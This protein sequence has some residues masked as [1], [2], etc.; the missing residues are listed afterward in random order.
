MPERVSNIRMCVYESPMTIEPD[1]ITRLVR[2]CEPGLPVDPTDPRYVNCDDVRGDFLVQSI[3]RSLQRAD[4][5]HPDC[6][7]FAGHRG[8]GKSSE[9]LRLK[10]MLERPASGQSPFRVIY[11][12]VAT[13]LDLNDLD[14]PDLLVYAAA[15]IQRQLRKAA[16]PKFSG[17]SQ[18]LQR[19]WD[20]FKGFLG[21]SVQFSGADVEIPF[22]SLP[23][24]FKNQPSGRETLRAG[25]ERVSTSL[26]AAVNELLT[27]ANLSLQDA[28]EKGVALIID[29]LDKLVLRSLGNGQTTHDRLFLDRGE[30]LASLRAHTIYTVP[31]SMI[32]SPRCTQLEQAFGEF[33]RPVAMIRLRGD[34]RSE[35]T[36]DTL[37]MQKLW[38]IVK[39]RCAFA[40]VD[41]ND[42]FDSEETCNYLCRMTGGHPRH[43]MVFLQAAANE[44]DSLPITRRAAERVV[45]SYA[46]S[47]LREIPTDFWPRLRE[48]ATP[49]DDIPKDEAHQEMLFY[50]HV[51]EYM[52][53]RPWYEVNPVLRTLPIFD[54]A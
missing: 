12:D 1:P 37:G 27:Q 44:C 43:L 6:K 36:P 16:I 11:F 35:P 30:Q 53:C 26:L 22:A 49:R 51:L 9:L 2:A 10:R 41:F 33:N 34:D 8:V 20:D 17:T 39:Q 52:N 21:S 14:F 47:L 3:A 46:N 23:L 48:F 32:Y 54:S 29:G 4:P 25:I 50:L 7:L 38:E 40:R 31:I 45:N 15:E 19:L 13:A 42:V 5:A 24:E 18:Y 28:G